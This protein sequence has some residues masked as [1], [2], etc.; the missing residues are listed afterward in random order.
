MIGHGRSWECAGMQ[1]LVV[2]MISLEEHLVEEWLV[3]LK[4]D[5]LIKPYYCNLRKLQVCSRSLSNSTSLMFLP[6]TEPKLL[7]GL[8]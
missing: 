6:W 2:I 3:A 4:F 8:L 1:L 7:Q 5:S